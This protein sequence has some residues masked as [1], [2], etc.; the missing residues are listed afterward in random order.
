M[1]ANGKHAQSRDLPVIMFSGAW[2]SKTEQQVHT[3]E[4]TEIIHRELSLGHLTPALSRPLQ[5]KW[6][7]VG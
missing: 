1:R 2:D 6:A 4:V 5:P 7:G 3:V